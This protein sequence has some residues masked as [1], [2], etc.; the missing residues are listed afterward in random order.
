MSSNTPPKL[1]AFRL[2]TLAAA[3]TSALLFNSVQAAG[4]GELSVH[5]SLG[6]PLR[7]DVELLLNAKDEE[8]ALQVKLASPDA[9][10][11]ANI[12]FNAALSSLR[13]VVDRSGNRHIVR[14][15]SAQPVNEPFLDL[16]LEVSG[17]S[18]RV[19]R[20][21]VLLLDPP[22]LYAAPAAQPNVLPQSGKIESR[23]ASGRAP[24]QKKLD[25]PIDK[26]ADKPIE[27][28]IEK[29]A[30]GKPRLTLSSATSLAPGRPAVNA[31]EYA[32]M[33]KAVTDANARVQS[34]E[35]KVDDLQKLLE[36]TNGLLVEMQK[37]SEIARANA[38]AMPVA[39]VETRPAPVS[40]ATPAVAPAAKQTKPV[41][42]ADP[43][44]DIAALLLP[45]AGLLAVLVGA[46]GVFRMRRKRMQQK[47]GAP[48]FNHSGK[49]AA[50]PSAPAGMPHAV[51]A[52]TMLNPIPLSTSAQ[53]D[54]NDVDVVSEADVYIAFGRDVQAEQVL[55]E[56]LRVQPQRHAA[57]VKLLTIYAARKDLAAFEL[58]AA[59]LYNMTKG[60]GEEW[61]QAATMGREIDPGNPLYASARHA[62]AN[63][64]ALAPAT[65][66]HSQDDQPEVPSAKTEIA[67]FTSTSEVDLTPLP[68]VPDFS[69]ATPVELLPAEDDNP[70]V[71]ASNT[72][73]FKLSGLN[74]EELEV[75]VIP[76]EPVFVP[77]PDADP[78]ALDFE[79]PALSIPAQAEGIEETAAASAIEAQSGSGPIDF[80]FLLPEIPMATPKEPDAPAA[81]DDDIGLMDLEFL[82]P[83][84]EEKLPR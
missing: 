36:A 47:A 37:Q 27:R 74:A 29:Q 6:Q 51:G 53:V 34:L 64:V 49:E 80:D 11:Q 1:H 54:P 81:A 72:L 12:E 21:Y 4:L 68:Q 24:S 55:K 13:F 5:S 59:E 10:R 30:S 84:A 2:T 28:P 73:D 33:E 63:M 70:P 62:T 9:Y 78:V 66:A 17:G 56:A 67:N 46:F 18:G 40:Q 82:E 77:Q 25:K 22:T 15:T 43:D 39:S 35:Q 83:E 14:V 52:T 48:L 32:A 71:R 44:M 41:A 61:A 3:L 75:P 65:P 38:Q 57:R 20:E 7:A 16:L 19:V 42:P 31:E 76:S 60:E 69:D 45:G 50:S 79:M 26:A 23:S 8:G 58:L